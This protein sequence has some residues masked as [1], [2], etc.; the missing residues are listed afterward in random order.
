MFTN[1]DTISSQ[2]KQVGYSPQLL[3]YIP[4][5]VMTDKYSFIHNGKKYIIRCFQQ[6]RNNQ[7]ELEY[8]YLSLF[9][10]MDIKA[11][12]P[13]YYSRTHQFP[14]LVYE[15]LE[16][17]TLSD[18][19]DS[20]DSKTQ[21]TLCDEIAINYLKITKITNSHFGQIVNF[22]EFKDTSWKAFICDA[23]E[24]AKKMSLQN[25]DKKMLNCCEKLERFTSHIEEPAPGLIWSDFSGDNII[26]SKDGI[27]SGFIDFEGLISGDPIF[28]IGYFVAHEKNKKLVSL[29]MDS[30][31]IMYDSTPVIFYSLIRLCRLLPYQNLPLLN[32][33][34][35]MSLKE[36]L[37]PAYRQIKTFGK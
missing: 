7:P 28:G 6:H 12:V 35:R 18:C 29:L 14:F 37:G 16:G 36:F 1:P 30:F 9:Q 22:K 13:C 2:L 21:K 25:K 33:E 4:R 5:G 10:S 11:P 17:E 15:R 20:F 32:G 3:T 26:V 23:I 19:F 24:T 34:K 31:N 27:L 8:K